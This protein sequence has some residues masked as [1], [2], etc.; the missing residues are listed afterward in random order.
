MLLIQG[1]LRAD[2]MSGQRGNKTA[3]LWCH[4]V[5]VSALR[6]Y[7]TCS[8]HHCTLGITTIYF[9]FILNQDWSTVSNLS[10]EKRLF[11]TNAASSRWCDDFIFAYKNT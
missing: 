11:A 10:D 9:S 8:I 4:I 6:V 3:H 7:A 5:P 2:G 1:E